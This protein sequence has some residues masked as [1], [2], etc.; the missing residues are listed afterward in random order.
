MK[1]KTIKI[2]PKSDQNDAQIHESRDQ[3]TSGTPFCVRH[4]FRS[5]LRQDF[6]TV[7]E[8]IG[9]HLG[10]HFASKIH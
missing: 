4:G 7:L 6:D 5:R 10:H 8:T 2:L 1:P 3:M 9:A